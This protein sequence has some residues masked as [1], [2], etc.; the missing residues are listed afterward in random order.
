MKCLLKGPDIKETLEKVMSLGL[1]NFTDV[2]IDYSEG[3]ERIED[4]NGLERMKVKGSILML[5]NELSSRVN[6]VLLISFFFIDFSW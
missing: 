1:K 5:I 6:I 4:S 3:V 2:K